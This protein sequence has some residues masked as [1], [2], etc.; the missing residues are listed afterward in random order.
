[1]EYIDIVDKCNKVI[2]SGERG[3]VHNEKLF[4]RAVH[5]FIFNSKGELFVQK[6]SENK[7][8]HP[9]K[10]DSSAAGHLD[11]GESYDDAAKREL[12]EEL[13]ISVPLKKIMEIDACRETGNE[14]VRVYTAITDDEININR[15]EIEEG[16]FWKS[17]DIKDKIKNREDAFTPAFILLFNSCFNK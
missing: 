9:W 12:K 14:F 7:K 11:A 10:Y 6:R 8:E 2:R 1:M 5:I 17:E 15:D 3:C 4:H 13:G 16:H